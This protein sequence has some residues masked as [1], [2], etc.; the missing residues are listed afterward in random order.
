VPDVRGM[1]LR[2]AIFL[3]ENIGLKVKFSG[4][5]SVISQSLEPG[6]KIIKGNSIILEL[7]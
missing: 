7:S 2:D 6:T 5:G 4:K 3:L 1:G